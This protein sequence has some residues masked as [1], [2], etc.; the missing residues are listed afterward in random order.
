MTNNKKFQNLE[1]QE[2]VSIVGETGPFFNLSNGSNIKKDIFFQKFSEMVDPSSFFEKKSS[3]NLLELAEKLKNIDTSKIQDIGGDI[4]PEIKYKERYV[5][6]SPEPTPEYK[7]MLLKQ[8]KYKQEHKDLSQYKV[9]DNDE[10]AAIDF[11]KRL[12]P[13]LYKT[14]VSNEN[15]NPI[16]NNP[17]PIQ[18][19]QNQPLTPEQESF[20]F[21]KSFKKIFPITL[22]IDFEEKIADPIFIKMMYMNYEGDIIKFYTKEFMNRIYNDPGFLENKIYEKLKSIIFEENDK[23][24]KKTRVSKKPSLTVKKPISKNKNNKENIENKNE[25]K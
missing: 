15:V 6:D 16:V 5:S 7:E 19:G 12:N 17:Q 13:D 3:E 20:K 23:P 4:Q 25:L 11:E 9:Y 22:S 21:F 2:I 8:Y 24:V 1:T 18:T 10:D 14:E